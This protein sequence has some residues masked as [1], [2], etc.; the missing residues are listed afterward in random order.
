ML[1]ANLGNSLS[2]APD[3]HIVFNIGDT[4]VT[5]TYA[6]A[7]IP[8][9]NSGPAGQYTETLRASLTTT[10]PDVSIFSGTVDIAPQEVNASTLKVGFTPLKAANAQLGP[11]SGNIRINLTSLADSGS[12]LR[13]TTLDPINVEV[14]GNAYQAA[15]PLLNNPIVRLGRPVYGSYMA[16]ME[17]NARYNDTGWI[18]SNA[19]P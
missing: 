4:R 10:S 5:G 19:D 7:F 1:S 12:G 18:Y 14:V 8:L 16:V 11:T 9:K 6:D 15:T 2:L 13:N 3:G 17:T